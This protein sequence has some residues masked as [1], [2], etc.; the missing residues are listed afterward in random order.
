M[1]RSFPWYLSVVFLLTW[2]LLTVEIEGTASKRTSTTVPSSVFARSG[3]STVRLGIRVS[4]RTGA[5]ALS[6]T[7]VLSVV[8]AAFS[9]GWNC[10]AIRTEQSPIAFLEALS[11]CSS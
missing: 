3:A 8:L 11:L 7:L 1:A 9:G 2:V 6:V 10:P 4:G 5:I